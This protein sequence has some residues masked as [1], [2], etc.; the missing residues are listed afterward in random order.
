MKKVLVLVAALVMVTAPAF[1]LTI[2]GSKHD[3][4][5]YGTANTE[6]CVYCHTPHGGNTLA[7][8]WNRGTGTAITKTYN[9]ATFDMYVA[10]TAATLTASDAPLCL[11]CHDGA[12]NFNAVTNPP[13]AALANNTMAAGNAV[14]GTDLSN[15]HPIGFSY[16]DAQTI[17]ANEL[18]LFAD[19]V[20]EQPG[21]A[22][23]LFGSAADQMWCSSCHDVHNNAIVPFLRVNNASSNLCLACHLK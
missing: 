6:L 11:S 9:S 13:A 1:A 23:G 17:A 16:V 14:L 7:P 18:A 21:L 3:L 10:P 19:A 8:L 5:T 20:T 22:G 12:T 15:D 2:D 4:S